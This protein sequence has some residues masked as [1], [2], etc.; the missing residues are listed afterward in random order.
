MNNG[1]NSEAIRQLK[2]KKKRIIAD[3]NRL[4][5]DLKTADD[6]IRLL[7]G[8]ESTDD[9]KLSKISIIKQFLTSNLGTKYTASQIFEGITSSGEFNG[10][11]A[12]LHNYLHRLVGKKQIERDDKTNPKRYYVTK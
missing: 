8:S 7:G 4:N 1:S 5:I 10:K 3:I 11:I 12:L 9:V 2:E 6:A